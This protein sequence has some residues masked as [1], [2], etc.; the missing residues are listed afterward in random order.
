VAPGQPPA[1]VARGLA[2]ARERIA[3]AF[4]RVCAKQ[5]IDALGA[6]RP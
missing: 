2:E 1:R 3:A 6:S 5:T 4:E